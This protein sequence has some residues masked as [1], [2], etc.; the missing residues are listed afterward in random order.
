[1]FSIVFIIT[2]INVITPSVVHAKNFSRSVLW[3]FRRLRIHHDRQVTALPKAAP[4]NL[5]GLIQVLKHG[6]SWPLSQLQRVTND[7]RIYI[8][9][10][11]L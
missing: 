6:A 1:M 11:V 2:V 10:Y 3:S 7:K 5:S 9:A 8:Y 4:E